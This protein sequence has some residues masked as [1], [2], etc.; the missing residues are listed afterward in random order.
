[1]R[2]TSAV[3][4]CAAEPSVAAGPAK[5]VRPR[6]AASVVLIDRSGAEPKILLG[7]RNARLA[8]L[9]GK[10]VFPGGRLEADDALMPASG[11]LAERCLKRLAL[12]RA[13][14]N[15][16]PEA[17]A[18]AA[19][20]ELFEETGLLVGTP[21]TAFPA[22]VPAIWKDFCGCGF[23]PDLAALR[24]VARALTPPALPRRFDTSFFLVEAGAIAYRV[25]GRIGDDCEFVELEWLPFAAAR[26]RDI[27]RITAM[28]LQEVEAT[29]AMDFDHL[30]V[31]FFYERKRRWIREEL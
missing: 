19:I 7:R 4:D 13:R 3:S 21:C 11:A 27:P 15:P 10:Y 28:I 18:L 16:P 30:R 29:I 17:F 22:P 6:P 23:A 2:E 12:R 5:R 24:F 1:M 26:E 20:R 8:F 31:P 14:S 25:D 9:P